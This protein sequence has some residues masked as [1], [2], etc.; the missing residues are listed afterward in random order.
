MDFAQILPKGCALIYRHFGR[1]E[2][3][4]DGAKLAAIAKDRGFL[5]LVSADPELADDV[6]AAGIHWPVRMLHLA[7]Q[8]RKENP[9]QVMT[10]SAHNREELAL[11]KN[12]KA[13]AA[14]LSP[15]FPT[16]SPNSG[17]AIGT[18][19]ARTLVPHAGVPVYAL[20]G[21]TAETAGHLA[22]IGFSGIASIDGFKG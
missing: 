4:D 15:I 9:D 7:R 21:I 16:K 3:F 22:G 20:G 13:D 2:R 10:L 12:I 6:G 17:P 11:A 19:R 5:L 18:L 14:L 1:P 8:W